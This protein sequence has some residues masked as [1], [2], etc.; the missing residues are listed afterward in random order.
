[1]DRLKAKK[2]GRKQRLREVEALL[3]GIKAERNVYAQERDHALKQLQSSQE[4]NQKMKQQ[5]E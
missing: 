1:M 3:E 2:R 4:E 5:L